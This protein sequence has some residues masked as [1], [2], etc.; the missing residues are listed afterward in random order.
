MEF[1]RL[2]QSV[3]IVS[4][5][6][7]AEGKRISQELLPR[8]GITIFAFRG[9]EATFLGKHLSEGP[10]IFPQH[11]CFCDSVVFCWVVPN[12]NKS[13]LVSKNQIETAA[14]NKTFFKR[15]VINWALTHTHTHTHPHP[16]KKRSHSPTPTHIQPNKMSHSPTP[17]H[18]QPKKKSHSPTPTH[19]EPYKGHTHPHPPTPSQK[20]VTLTHTH[21]HQT[22]SHTYPHPP[23]PS[24]KM[25][26]PTHTQ[27]KK[28]H[29]HPNPAINLGKE[30]FHYPLG[31]QIYQKLK[32]SPI[33]IDQ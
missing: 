22:K 8:G 6:L 25:V 2:I 29:N 32:N 24:Q 1:L 26:T 31:N 3:P 14:L 5:P 19:I 4:S 11:F 21:P 9:G 13:S 33:P 27:P 17:T 10:V 30:V 12:H 20:K 15:A 18:T 23:T 7:S 16:A 28:G